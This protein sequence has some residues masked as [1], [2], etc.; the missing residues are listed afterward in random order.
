MIETEIVKNLKK[1]QIRP[2]NIR[3]EILGI[4]SETEFALSHNDLEALTEHKYDRVTIY[5]TLDLL[6][7][8][9]II[10]RVIDDTGIAKYSLTRNEPQ[11]NIEVNKHLH[12]KCQ[13]CGHTYCFSTI[14]LPEINFPAQLKGTSLDVSA[15][16]V[17][18]NCLES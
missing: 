5:R 3:K 8:K 1:S 14:D 18:H 11:E 15:E 17:C 9:S 7:S 4:F 13:K 6:C 2:T 12:F 10:H 16:G